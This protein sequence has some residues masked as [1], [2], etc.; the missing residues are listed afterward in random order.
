MSKKIIAFLASPRDRGNTEIVLDS[1]LNGA[2]EAGA[3][4]EKI[5][6]NRKNIKLC[7]GLEECRK[8][9]VCSIDDDCAYLFQS[10]IDSDI[11][12]LASP[13]YWSSYTSQLKVFLDRWGVF[14]SDKFE[15]RIPAKKFVLIAVCGNPNIEHAEGVIDDMKKSIISL[16]PEIVGELTA[17][18]NIK[19]DI[20]NDIDV[21]NQAFEMGKGVIS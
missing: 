18:A 20:K 1:F 17:S 8:T 2:H 10:I 3:E 15:S 5:S 16:K 14:L 21:L 7:Q 9:G 11:V 12:V 6:L 13:N 19:G 4:I